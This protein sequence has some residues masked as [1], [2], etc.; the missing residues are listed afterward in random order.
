MPPVIAVVVAG[1]WVGSAAR[2]ALEPSRVLALQGFWETCGF[3]INVLLFLLVG[4]QIE[5]RRL[6]S[7]AGPIA[8]ALLALHLG[9]A[10]SVYGSFGLL[11]IFFQERIPMKW[12]HVMMLGTST[13]LCRWPPCSRCRSP[14]V[15]RSVGTIVFGVTFMTL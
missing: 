12:Q 5:G 2:S 13:A 11:R 10:V 14:C 7:E 8:L 1:L 4:M 9:R 6:I 15:P 3:A